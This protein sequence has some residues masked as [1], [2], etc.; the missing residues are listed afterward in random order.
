M[1]L[2][3]KTRLNIMLALL[4][5]IAVG[6]AKEQ[7]AGETQNAIA[8]GRTIVVNMPEMT[9]TALGE[10][11]Q[12]GVAV[13]WSAGDEIAVIEGKGTEAQKVSTYR[14]VGEGGTAAGTFEYVSGEA[15]AEVITD[16]VFPASAVENGY[17]VPTSQTYVE[18][19]FDTD[20]MVMSWTRSA[21][22]ENITLAHEASALMFTVTGTAEQK[23]SSVAVEC[24]EKTYTLACTEPVALTSEGVVFYVAVPG[25]E[26]SQDYV[27]TFTAE[28]GE[29]LT[30]D[31]TYALAAGKIGR[32]PAFPFETAPAV[33]SLKVGDYFRGG[34]VYKIADGYAKIV[35]LDEKTCYWATTEAKSIR[36]GTNANA[37]EGVENTDLFRNR[38]DLE[39]F[40]AAAWCIAHGEGWY[41]PSRTEI[42]E[43]V[44]GLELETET[45][46][47]K[48]NELFVECLGQGFT[49]GKSYLTSCEHST[50]DE[51]V[52]TVTIPK[53]S[54]NA[55]TKAY[56]RH[57]RAVKKI[58]LVGGETADP[59]P[60]K[61]IE[62]QIA[63]IADATHT[64]A[65]S[66]YYSGTN[67]NIYVYYNTSGDLRRAGYFQL[68][69]S[70]LD[71]EKVVSASLNLSIYKSKCDFYDFESL[72]FNAYKVDNGWEEVNYTSSLG[73][74][75]G[76]WTTSIEAAASTTIL[77]TA[78][79][80]E[81]D[82]TECI[83][84]AHKND[85]TVISICIQ[86]PNTNY[87]NVDGTKTSAKLYLYSRESSVAGVQPYLLVTAF[88]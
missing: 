43:I 31:F 86:S 40:P 60:E 19:S 17:A 78:E 35:S 16:I 5:L 51:Q 64:N 38:E 37:A 44:N 85:E 10:A 80:L 52:W 25:S 68:D 42:N 62:Q 4:T 84:T 47:D 48:V 57:V 12:T 46:F 18:G 41:M 14:L 50:N 87:K 49:S 75:K 28:G 39:S 32:L 1:E 53:K 34:I 88:K 7:P 65:N 6:C 79:K 71:A 54:H 36:I 63:V 26:T 67:D 8:E 22:E 56:S 58:A 83:K 24:G 59:K 74:K 69:I 20:A 30:K 3:M 61:P 72:T 77:P 23:I 55:Y 45:E 82:I 15:S 13:V 33:E 9:T 21:E 11:T 29:T 70:S 81:F 76:T 2:V 73:K 66:N 27:V